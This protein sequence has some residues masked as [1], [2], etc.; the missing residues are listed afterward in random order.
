MAHLAS[1]HYVSPSIV[2]SLAV[3]V[4]PTVFL[5]LFFSATNSRSWDPNGDQGAYAGAMM[6]SIQAL[7]LVIYSAVGFPFAALWLKRRGHYRRATFMLA[8]T[9]GLVLLCLVV[10]FLLSFTDLGGSGMY[11]RQLTFL[12]VEAMVFC[13]PFTLLWF[14]LAR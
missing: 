13:L 7:A 5:G 3:F 6:F 8:N 14:R 1:R 9:A 2:T 4:L 11:L 10:A 12:L